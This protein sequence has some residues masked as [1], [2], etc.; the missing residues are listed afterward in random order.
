MYDIHQKTYWLIPMH[1]IQQGMLACFEE[2]L[3]QLIHSCELIGHSQNRECTWQ[4]LNIFV[5]SMLLLVNM[6]NVFTSYF[7]FWYSSVY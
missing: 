6:L 3:I 1:Y 2:S 5:R 7:Y 4:L